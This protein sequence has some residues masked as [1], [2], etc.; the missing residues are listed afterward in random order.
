MNKRT[1]IKSIIFS[2]LLG[3]SL[4]WRYSLLAKGPFL[5]G[6]DAYYY[7]LQIKFFVMTGFLKIHDSSPLLQ[8]MGWTGKAGLSCEQALVLWTVLIQFF[9]LISVLYAYRLIRNG[10]SGPLLPALILTWAALSPTLTFTCIEFPKYAFALIF[11]PLWPV[12]LVNQKLWPVSLGAV[13]LSFV[14]HLAMIGLLFLVLF[15]IIIFR[16]NRIRL[17]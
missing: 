10:N 9:C 16:I 1:I 5:N 2:L 3:L 15:G 13:I 14:S 11:L 12:G 8:L 4:I 6:P 17:D 7:A